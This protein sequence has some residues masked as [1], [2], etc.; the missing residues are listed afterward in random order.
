[1]KTAVSD[2]ADSSALQILV[3]DD[4]KHVVRLLK[5]TLERQG[6]TVTCAYDGKEA[7]E[8]LEANPT[9]FD[10]VILDV[11]M[12][13]TDGFEVLK[14]IRETQATRHLWVSM[15]MAGSQHQEAFERLP[16]RANKYVA[17]PCNP[18]GLV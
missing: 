5:V 14:W 9:K 3:R 13:R 2:S 7:I 15:M 18:L 6:H 11:M 8:V 16:Y 4:E 10:R 1:M 12:P 17:K